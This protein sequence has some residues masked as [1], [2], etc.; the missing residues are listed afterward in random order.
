MDR[1]SDMEL[2]LAIADAGGMAAGG[3][4]LG[5]SPATVSARIVGLEDRL[6][7]Q[8]LTRTT[9]AISLTNEGRIFVEDARRIV[10]QVAD[11]EARLRAGKGDLSGR[12]S[13]SAPLD[14]GRN[15]LSALIDHFLELHPEVTVDLRLSD[16]L[17][18]LVSGDVDCALR[19]GVP[20]DS[21]LIQR[22]LGN[23]RRI[24]CAAP[25]YIA[26]KGSPTHPGD[27][28]G[29]D[30]LVMLFGDQAQD[31]W[32]FQNAGKDVVIAVKPARRANDGELIRRWAIAGHGIAMK[33]SW[34]IAEDL[35][36]GRLVPMLESFAAPGSSLSMVW[37]AGRHL[38]RRTRAFID[39]VAEHLGGNYEQKATSTID[40]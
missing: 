1:L 11:L 29:H 9:R 23:S 35:A 26:R 33:S 6:G 20:K 34:D 19:Y 15:R 17:V 4:R 22:R 31:R 7:V 14:F 10:D 27:L 12:L 8:L 37:P 28:E 36:E 18:D 16:G 38:A 21:S 2:I 24:A 3:R 32:Q 40:N 25:A 5:L 30:C 39:Y 13:I